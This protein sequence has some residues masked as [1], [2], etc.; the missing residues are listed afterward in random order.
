MKEFNKHILE[1]VRRGI[2]LA[3][4]DYQ[5]IEPNS[6]TSNDIINVEDVIQ[7][8]IDLDKYTVDLGLP[9]GTRW[10]KFNLGCDF[11][12]L[13]NH[14]NQTKPEDWYG[15]YYAWGETKPKDEYNKGS[16]KFGESLTKY[17]KEDQL[18]HLLSEDDAAY[19]NMHIGNYEFHIPTK[20]QFE[21]LFTINYRFIKY[22][23]VKN[24]YGIMFK[25]KNGNELFL[26][27][28]GYYSEYGY[29]NDNI[30]FYWSQNILERTD[31]MSVSYFYCANN[32]TASINLGYR[33]N[34]CSIRPVYN[35]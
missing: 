8:R 27:A 31:K 18:T 24:L 6:S 19:Q 33:T 23:H 5:D 2:R 11:N 26:P 14:P 1:A 35:K 34:G 17:N 29:S 9:S 13:N 12:L 32:N 21:E 20:E 3:L 22:K 10:C 7:N 15:D 16:Y 30:C 4:D 25:G 28:A